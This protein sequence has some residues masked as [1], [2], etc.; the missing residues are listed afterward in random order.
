M[1]DTQPAKSTASR[2]RWLVPECIA[3]GLWIY[4]LLTL[5]VFDIDIYFLDRFAP[6]GSGGF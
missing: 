4:A 5:A 3:A 1:A 2:L 6:R